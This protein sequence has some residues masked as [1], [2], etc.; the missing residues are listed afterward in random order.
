MVIKT[1]SKEENLQAVKIVT[2]IEQLL[3]IKIPPLYS[4][5][6]TTFKVD[7]SIGVDNSCYLDKYLR[8]M[9][10]IYGSIYS[11]QEKGMLFFESFMPLKKH[12]VN[13]EISKQSLSSFKMLNIGHT[14][15]P[16]G[17]F[18]GI[19]QN[20]LDKIYWIEWENNNGE[21]SLIAEDIFDFL[22]QLKIDFRNESS[23]DVT[24]IKK[25]P[26]MYYQKE[27]TQILFKEDTLIR[28]SESYKKALDDSQERFSF[29]YFINKNIT[30]Q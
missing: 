1:L 27:G 15:E 11:E 30:I 13:L 5:F 8:A 22:V 18:L 10:L 16:P 6:I 26:E 28:L 21:P 25:F 3:A 24:Y 7:L 14:I 17:L 29:E 19:E 4:K 2:Q 23:Q 20:N 12:I 9:P